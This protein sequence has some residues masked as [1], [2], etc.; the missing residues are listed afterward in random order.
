MTCTPTRLE[1]SNTDATSVEVTITPDPGDG[2]SVYLEVPGLGITASAVTT[3]G[4]ASYLL[5]ALTQN[6]NSL[7]DGTIQVNTNAPADI[8]VQI[9]E[10]ASAQVVGVTV[11]DADVSYCAPTGG[12]GG[13]IPE[14]PNDGQQYGRQSESWTVV[15]GVEP[16]PQERKY[17]K[18]LNII[19]DQMI[20]QR[21]SILFIGDSI[22]NPVVS[23][24]MRNGYEEN[25]RPRYWRGISPGQSNG[26][27]GDNGWSCT[28]A[29]GSNISGLDAFN[30]PDPNLPG[31]DSSFSGRQSQTGAGDWYNQTD[32]VGGNTGVSANFEMAAIK[33]DNTNAPN[34]WH[35]TEQGEGIENTFYDSPGF[36]MRTLWYAKSSTSIFADYRGVAFS[37]AS[38]EAINLTAGWNIVEKKIGTASYATPQYAATKFY[39]QMT[40]TDSAQLVAS[41][42]FSDEY[43]G[44][45]MAYMGGGGWATANHRYSDDTAPT[46]AGSGNRSCW[47]LDETAEKVM[48]LM[49]TDIV[50]IQLGANDNTLADHTDHLEAVL[51]RFRSIRPG[52]RF[53]LI[54][55]YYINTSSRWSEQSDWQRNLAG[56][57]G[58]TDVAFLDLYNMVADD[59][60][61]YATFAAS[62][63]GDGL[64]PNASGSEYMAGLEWNEIL[65]AASEWTA[66]ATSLDGPVIFTARNDSGGTMTK[67]QAVYVSGYSGDRTLVGLAD[68]D[69]AA[70]MPAFGLVNSTTA[71]NQADVE[72]VTYGEITGMDTSSFS[73]GD[74]VYVS[75]TPGGLQNTPPA[76]ESSLIQNMGKVIRDHAT[77]GS[78]KVIGA[79][80]TNATPNLN[81]G[82]IFVGNSSN[83]SATEPF[84]NRL[85]PAQDL[86]TLTDIPAGSVTGVI[87]LTQA[88]Y[89]DITTPVATVL[90]VIV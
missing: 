40:T 81:D 64:H 44:L 50:A 27:P 59:Q 71:N 72:I 56:S 89:D 12:G 29:A 61:D 23:G 13:G 78:I 85:S 55:Q 39:S 57:A 88:E 62:Y 45:S 30:G 73:P 79:G 35:G 9:V 34:L 46:V 48:E 16:I 38:Q 76:G 21:A 10:T 84:V 87:E 67:G 77:E 2:T 6:T 8:V 25:W 18:N 14:A 51:D 36:T 20:G 28:A 5:G 4:V 37:V 68:C 11:A 60:T 52:V 82:N 63:L 41:Y 42:V 17:S 33:A 31:L 19:A 66:P 69:V 83:Q 75:A 22:N 74:V 86:A 32:S 58:N 80:R 53:L 47:Y 26:N 65:A 1:L 54:S 24:Y 49:D 15:D 7:W 43:D 90:Y 70:A 3:G